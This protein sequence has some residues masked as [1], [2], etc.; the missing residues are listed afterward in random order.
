MAPDIG[1]SLSTLSLL[2]VSPPLP[3]SPLFPDLWLTDASGLRFGVPFS[4][5]ISLFDVSRCHDF[6]Y[7]KSATV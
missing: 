2:A 1:G 5:L 7:H 3:Q 6:G 4:P